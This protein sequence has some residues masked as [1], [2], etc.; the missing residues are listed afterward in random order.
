[1]LAVSVEAGTGSL[2]RVRAVLALQVVWGR[3]GTVRVGLHSRVTLALLPELLSVTDT[4]ISMFED[5]L[6]CA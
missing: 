5:G 4:L 3:F 6:R 2:P 1:M